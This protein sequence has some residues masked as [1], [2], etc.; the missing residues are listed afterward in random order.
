LA[1]HRR[2][3]TCF[4]PQ[5]PIHRTKVDSYSRADYHRRVR[6]HSPGDQRRRVWHTSPGG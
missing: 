4:P 1:A 2:F 5:E 3:Y 6:K